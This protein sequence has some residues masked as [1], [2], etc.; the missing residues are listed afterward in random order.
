MN[1]ASAEIVDQLGMTVEQL[2]Q[3]D[4]RAAEFDQAT[5]VFVA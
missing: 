4:G 1:T 3:L 5:L 2:Q